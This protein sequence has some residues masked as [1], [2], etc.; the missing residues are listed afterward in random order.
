[1]AK[2][3]Y[4]A[5]EEIRAKSGS[6]QWTALYVAVGKEGEE[7]VTAST[8]TGPLLDSFMGS[9]QQSGQCWR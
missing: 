6:G 4:L 8:T 2:S 9:F 5:R 3:A 7:P 1:M